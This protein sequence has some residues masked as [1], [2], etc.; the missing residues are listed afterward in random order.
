MEIQSHKFR[1]TRTEQF[2]TKTSTM[3]PN[4]TAITSCHGVCKILRLLDGAVSLEQDPFV[5]NKKSAPFVVETSK[6]SVT[7]AKNCS[8]KPVL[9]LADMTHEEICVVWYS[10]REFKSFKDDCRRTAKA[11]TI[12]MQSDEM[13]ER[14][15]EPH[16]C[17]VRNNLRRTLKKVGRELVLQEQEDQINEGSYCPE[18]IAELYSDLTALPIQDA[19][20]IALQDE[21]AARY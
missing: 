21:K 9:H 12:G 18:F 10:P 5:E 8:A 17:R 6:K 4:A 7:W 11:F 1:Q 16:I 14:G 3:T 13:C 15:L 20:A 2:Q 19:H